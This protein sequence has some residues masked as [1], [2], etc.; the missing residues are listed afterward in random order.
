MRRQKVGEAKVNGVD[1]HRFGHLIQSDLNGTP[2]VD[3]TMTTH[4][5]R[6][7]FVGPDTSPGVMERTEFVGSCGQHA[8][9]V[10][11]D[12][13]EGSKTTTVDEGVDVET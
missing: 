5:T 6:S 12:V 1:V 3:G 2:R 13:A 11:S 4:G 8:V 9:V 7:R 10:G